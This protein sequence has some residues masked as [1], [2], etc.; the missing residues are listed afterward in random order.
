MKN[1][2]KSMF[3]DHW[4]YLAI[5]AACKL[6]IFDKV[7]EGQNT[8][9]KLIQNNNWNSEALFH[10]IKFLS[11]NQFINET[12]GFTIT[13]TEK[14]NLLREGNPDGLFYA[15]INW[16]EEHMN[17]WQVLQFSI[18]TG[19]SAFEH[20]YRKPYF[21]YLNEHPAKLRKYHKAMAEY[22]RDDYMEIQNVIDFG[23]HRS[24]MDVGGGYGTAISL[25]QQKN[26][27]TKCFLFDLEKVVG[28]SEIVKVE[29]VEGDFFEQIPA[30][31]EAIILS[32]VLH[33]WNNEKAAVILKNCFNALPSKGTLYVIENC[34]DSSQ[35]DLSLLTLNMTVMCQSF[36]RSSAEY[37]KL[38]EPE[39]FRFHSFKK[40]NQLQTIL[41]FKK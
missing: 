6:G 3:T 5:N 39:G 29:K 27:N 19:E 24:I 10:L 38:A 2:L 11:T 40:L 35:D 36:E 34:L 23:A 17:A 20:I 41:I 30:Y 16:S 32:R 31:A 7:F 21:D 26:L 1:E 22:A 8:T 25:I 28:G 14:G 37:I 12:E 18:E 9:E 15:C 33:D 13:L 4:K